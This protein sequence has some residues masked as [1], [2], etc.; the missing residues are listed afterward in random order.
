[1]QAGLQ[2]LGKHSKHE[3]II[4]VLEHFLADFVSACTFLKSDL[5]SFTHKKIGQVYLPVS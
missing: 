2:H 1:M 4:L 3:A 5:P